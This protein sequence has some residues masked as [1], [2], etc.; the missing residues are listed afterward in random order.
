MS[1]QQQQLKSAAIATIATCGVM[2]VP[3]LSS[4]SLSGS[5]SGLDQA[6]YALPGQTE[7]QVADWIR[8]NPALKPTRS[9][10]LLVKKSDTAARR[11]QF[12]ASVLIPGI[13][14]IPGDANLIRS[15]EI[16]FFDAVNGVTRDRL[17]DSVRSIYGASIMRDY[18]SAKTVYAYPTEEMIARAK[19]NN[20]NVLLIALQGELREG[21]QF[22]YWLETVEN[23]SGR[24]N[25]G[26][27]VIFERKHLPKLE[28]ELRKREVT[29]P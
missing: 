12:Q 1:Q 14:N 28:A 16:S 29:L 13:A 2:A 21:E 26:R 4:I 27:V 22:V 5:L 19:V 11:F 25:S 24:A 7:T 15:E 6:A 23:A 20:G 18:V 9:E 17:E 10:R 3:G 8:A